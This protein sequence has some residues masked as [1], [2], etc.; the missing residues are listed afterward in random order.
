MS[1]FKFRNNIW[2]ESS[3]DVLVPSNSRPFNNNDSNLQNISRVPFKANPIKHWRKQLFPYYQT[4][5][6]KQISIDQINAPSTAISTNSNNIDCSNKNV[7][8]LKENIM[9]LRTCDG[10]KVELENGVNKTKCTG[11][12]NHIRRSANTNLSKNY[13]RNYN[14]YLKSK[15]RT[16]EDNSKLG[17]KKDDTNINFNSSKCAT[18]MLSDG[19]TCDKTIIYKPS[20]TKY[21]VQGAVSSSTNILRKKN[22]QISKNN[23]SLRKYYNNRVV[24][25]TNVYDTGSGTG[26]HLNYIKGKNIE[27][28]KGCEKAINSIRGKKTVNF[29]NSIV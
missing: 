26:Y 14:S 28:R 2:K 1:K 6:S 4:K 24:S 23:D 13:Y 21:S 3:T 7:L 12:T 20:N 15:C 8:I 27:E 17:T 9:L 29:T 22:D 18:N 19:S 16:Y 11:G 5:S 25:L 10:I